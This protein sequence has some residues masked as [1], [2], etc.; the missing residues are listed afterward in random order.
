M[1]LYKEIQAVLDKED[2]SPNPDEWTPLQK[3]GLEWGRKAFR[4]VTLCD[5]IVAIC[6]N[7]KYRTKHTA[8]QMCKFLDDLRGQVLAGD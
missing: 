6:E 5:Q 4:F 8:I 7:P 2:F 1:N 3:H